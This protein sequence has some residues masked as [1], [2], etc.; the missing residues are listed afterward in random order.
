[1]MY[2]YKVFLFSDAPVFLVNHSN[3][4]TVHRGANV[5]LSCEAGGDPPPEYQ[6][7]VDDGLDILENSSELGVV[8]VNRSA[9][10]SC[11]ASNKLGN[12]TL[13]VQV[14]VP[15]VTR[16]FVG[17]APGPEPQRT[18]SRLLY[19]HFSVTYLSC[20]NSAM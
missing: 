10:Y 5:S 11:R 12:I 17:A 14:H 19:K 16:T 15:P 18:R 2:E 1:M 4:I 20:T 6:W 9:T 8:K 13:S 3:Y 7:T